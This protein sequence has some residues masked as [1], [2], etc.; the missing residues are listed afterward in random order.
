MCDLGDPCERERT[1]LGPPSPGTIDNDERLI[2]VV[3]DP[4]HLNPKKTAIK[5]GVIRADHLLNGE[6][7]VWRANLD[8]AA[9]IEA[10]KTYL[11]EHKPDGQEILH[12]ATLSVQRIRETPDLQGVRLFC[13]RDDTSIDNEGG[14][15][16]EHATIGFCALLGDPYKSQESS[17]FIF[18]RDFLHAEIQNAVSAGECV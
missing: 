3:Y 14:R 2:R 1:S 17:E 15:H 7:S 12:F 18:A 4:L 5:K 8:D 10:T 16:A 9:R 6:L 11:Q 13:V